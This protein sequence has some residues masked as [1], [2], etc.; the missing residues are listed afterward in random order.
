V[1]L[2]LI[3]WLAKG[4]RFGVPRPPVAKEYR[5]S[6]EYVKAMAQLFQRGQARGYALERILRWAEDESKR[7][8]VDM[9]RALIK[10]LQ[11]VRQRLQ[12]GKLRDGE[13]L[14]EAQRLYAALERAKKA[15]PGG[16]KR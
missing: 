13:L 10:T 4:R 1:V 11:S 16:G 15:A 2:L 8:L 3:L 9:D 14:G 6:M 7:L 12:G 5:S